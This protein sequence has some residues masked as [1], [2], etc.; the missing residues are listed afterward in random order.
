[1]ITYAIY[2]VDNL[3]EVPSGKDRAVSNKFKW[4]SLLQK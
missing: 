2:A 4:E 3:I 1:M